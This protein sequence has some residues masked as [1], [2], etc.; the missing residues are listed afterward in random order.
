MLWLILLRI[1]G[2]DDAGDEKGDV[3]T[4]PLDNY[5]GI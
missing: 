3:C 2:C 1:I 4:S 5:F